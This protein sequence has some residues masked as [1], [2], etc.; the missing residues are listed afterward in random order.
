[1]R[2]RRFRSLLL[3]EANNRTRTMKAL[4]IFWMERSVNDL[5]GFKVREQPVCLVLIERA[6][7][8]HLAFALM[9]KRQD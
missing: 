8:R 5:E 2:E 1:M 6:E 4:T 9:Y 7:S 3:S